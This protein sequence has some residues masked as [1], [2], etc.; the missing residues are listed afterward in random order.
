[1]T[2]ANEHMDAAQ[3]GKATMEDVTLQNDSG[4]DLTF[5]GK[6]YA[7]HSFFDDE[8]RVLTQQRLYITSEGHQAYSVIASDGKIKERR[9]YLIKSEGSLCK[10]NNGLFDVTVKADDLLRVVKGLCGISE[11]MRTADFFVEVQ[12]ALKNAANG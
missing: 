3:D 6:L 10:I 4:E 5:C 11:S 1:M 12:D 9:A 2:K 7:E 8:S